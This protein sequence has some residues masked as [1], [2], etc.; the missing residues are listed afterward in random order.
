[1]TWGEVSTA[2]EAHAKTSKLNLGNVKGWRESFC[3]DNN[4]DKTDLFTATEM[5]E[6]V[7]PETTTEEKTTTEDKTT[8]DAKGK[9]TEEEKTDA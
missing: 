5:P 9:G 3:R 4:T 7:T 2:L 1:M 8:T 6:V